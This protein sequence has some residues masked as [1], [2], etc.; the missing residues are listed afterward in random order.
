MNIQFD[1]L[2]RA[3][4]PVNVTQG[5]AELGIERRGRVTLI[6]RHVEQQLRSTVAL[7]RAGS[8]G[9]EINSI[10]AV[11]RVARASLVVRGFQ[12]NGV[13]YRIVEEELAGE[14][15]RLIVSGEEADFVMDVDR[16]SRVPAREDGG[17]ADP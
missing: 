6:L 2:R 16:S 14:L 15:I 10:P 1:A 9:A 3:A 4:H 7:H 8:R 12:K 5:V 11:P 17:D 13:R